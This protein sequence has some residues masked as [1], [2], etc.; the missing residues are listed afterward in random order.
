MKQKITCDDTKINM[1]DT[2]KDNAPTMAAG[3]FVWG[4]GA[5]FYLLAFF[6]G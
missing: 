2:F 1:T 4:F 3:L 6:T 5:V